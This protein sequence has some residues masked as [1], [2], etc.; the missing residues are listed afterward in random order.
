LGHRT[1]AVVEIR[2]P[3]GRTTLRITAIRHGD[4]RTTGQ[5][6]RRPHRRHTP[7]RSAREVV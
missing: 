2:V 3:A 6:P 5:A 7:S 1:G 4:T